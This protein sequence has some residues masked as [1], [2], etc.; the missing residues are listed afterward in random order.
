MLTIVLSLA[1]AVGDYRFVNSYP[2]WVEQHVVPLQRQG[3]RVWNASESGLR[4]YLEKTGVQTLESVDLRPEGGDLIVKQASFSYGLA[5]DLAPLVIP[6]LGA[7]LQ[8]SYPVRTFSREAGAG[9]HDSHFGIVPFTISSAVL[10]H[11]EIAE[12]SP[13]VGKLPQ[14]VPEDFSSVPLWF[15]GGVLLKQVRAEMRFE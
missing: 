1:L 11:V 9:F 13:F 6:I 2:Q 3:F 15:P 4:F 8:D 5:R 7:D 10:D 14:V 12:V